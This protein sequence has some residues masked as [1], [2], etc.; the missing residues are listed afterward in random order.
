M[1]LCCDDAVTDISRILLMIGSLLTHSRS[2]SI[3]K[4]QIEWLDISM[5]HMNECVFLSVPS[6]PARQLCIQTQHCVCISG[7]QRQ[8]GLCD[9]THLQPRLRL[10]HSGHVHVAAGGHERPGRVILLTSGQTQQA[11]AESILAFLLC[12]ICILLFF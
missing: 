2:T 5:W 8:G 7:A 3:W 6:L 12:F 11:A 1:C 9:V 10:L 4:S